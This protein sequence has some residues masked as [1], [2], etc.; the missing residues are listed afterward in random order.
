MENKVII[1]TESNKKVKNVEIVYGRVVIK[2]EKNAPIM[3]LASCGDNTLRVYIS[4]NKNSVVEIASL[5]STCELRVLNTPIQR[6]VYE[7]WIAAGMIIRKDNIVRFKGSNYEIRD[8]A[9]R[10]NDLG[11]GC[12]FDFETCCTVYGCND[13]NV[14]RYKH[15]DRPILF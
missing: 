7:R 10:N 14:I 1:K 13:T 3:Y 5:N 9:L 15:N 2:Y 6:E 4:E 8:N 11:L 12:I